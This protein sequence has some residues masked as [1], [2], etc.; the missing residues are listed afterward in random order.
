MPIAPITATAPRGISDGIL[1]TPLDA[2]FRPLQG[3]IGRSLFPDAK[4][5]RLPQSYVAHDSTTVRDA[6]AL[7]A[8]LSAWSLVDA[9]IG[10]DA[11][12][13]FGTYRAFQVVGITTIDD[14]ADMEDVPPEAVFYVAK[15]LWGYSYEA[16]FEGQRRTFTAGVGAHL[17]TVQGDM[18]SFAASH[19]LK[20]HFVG[21]GLRPKSSSALFARSPQ[22][23]LSAYGTAG[24]P[25][26]IFVEYRPVPQ[27]TLPPSASI[28]FETSLDATVRFTDLRVEEDGSWGS[29][30]WNLT[31]RCAIRGGSDPPMP[32]PLL[33]PDTR[34]D[35]GRTYTLNQTIEISAVPGD[36]LE[37]TVDGAYVDTIAHG[38]VA[39]GRAPEVSI[40]GPA[41]LPIAIRGLGG[42]SYTVNGEVEIHQ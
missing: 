20:M 42:T 41:R 13:R 5:S 21:A 6:L 19:H 34:V 15:V 39:P 30:P 23:V 18:N 11:E 36:I 1:G 12:T 32:V 3:A 14:T 9:S 29:T 33:P 4:V 22:E 40:L 27:R 31:A 2:H 25:S 35:G 37:C 16:V 7:E 8:N 28:P 38:S 17:A 10:Y 24:A 26:P